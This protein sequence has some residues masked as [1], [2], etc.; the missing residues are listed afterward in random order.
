[1]DFGRSQMSDKDVIIDDNI[2]MDSGSYLQRGPP[3]LR[4]SIKSSKHRGK[5]NR[6]QVIDDIDSD[7]DSIEVLSQSNVLGIN[8]DILEIEKNELIKKRQENIYDLMGLQNESHIHFKEIN[9]LIKIHQIQ[10][11]M[12]K[13]LGN[14]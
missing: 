2:S 14:R 9:E 1:M 3:S 12:L 8:E 13:G 11:Q 7:A 5:G 4:G 10:A 6:V